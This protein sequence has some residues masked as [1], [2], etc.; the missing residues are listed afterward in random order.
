MAVVVKTNNAAITAKNP[1]I[2]LFVTI[3]PL[4]S[5]TS[6]VDADRVAMAL[7]FANPLN[8]VL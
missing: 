6:F 1:P 5:K 4:I 8:F 3:D 2:P 7:P